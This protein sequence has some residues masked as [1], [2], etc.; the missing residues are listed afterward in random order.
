MKTTQKYLLVKVE[1][2]EYIN[3]GEYFYRAKEDIKKDINNNEALI[4]LMTDL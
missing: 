2:S 4:N 3:P 1:P